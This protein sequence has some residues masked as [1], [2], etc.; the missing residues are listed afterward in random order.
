MEYVAITDGGE[1]HI[2]VTDD[3]TQVVVDGQAHR[4]NMQ[5][6]GNR[7]LFSLL[8]DNSSHEVLI[9][10]VDEGFRVLLHGKL[11]TVRVDTRDRQRLSS[12]VNQRP[13]PMAAGAAIRAP[14][15]GMV[16][17]VPVTASE[18]VSAGQVLIV[19]ESMKMEN[20]VRAPQDGV[21]QS[22]KVAAGELVNANQVLL[23]VD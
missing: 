19:L 11:Y 8:V 20:E 21:V 22:V 15:P 14:M 7:T 5:D 13:V 10:E 17:S 16:V 23:V 18:A 3:D 9:E 1:L 12:L 6:I 4:V 2:E